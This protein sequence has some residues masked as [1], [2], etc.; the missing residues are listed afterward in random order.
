MTSAPFHRLF[1]GSSRKSEGGSRF[2][3][4]RIVFRYR[5]S[6]NTHREVEASRRK[7]DRGRLTASSVQSSR[8]DRFQADFDIAHPLAEEPD[9]PFQSNV[10]NINIL[11]SC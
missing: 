11:A 6:F 10:L 8:D 7:E 1:G 3:I 2:G 4:R 5:R 9:T